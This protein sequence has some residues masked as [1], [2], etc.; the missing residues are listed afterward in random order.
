M[1]R[2]SE[3]IVLV[4]I[5]AGLRHIQDICRPNSLPS[6]AWVFLL[7]AILGARMV[8]PA[9]AALAATPYQGMKINNGDIGVMLWGPHN[10]PTFNVAKADVWDRRFYGHK[11][12]VI[13]LAQIKEW[14]KTGD[15]PNRGYETYGA[16]D[17]PCP[18][19]VGQLIIGLPGTEA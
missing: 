19:P 2:Y 5:T 14:S 17:F 11:E 18:K 1:M 10:C 15:F 7:A 6:V 13:T 16:Y 4:G 3:M 9:E 8:L 12:P